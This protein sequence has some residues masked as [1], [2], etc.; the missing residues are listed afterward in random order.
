ML[1]KNLEKYYCFINDINNEIKNNILKFKNISL[2]YRPTQQQLNNLNFV[3][4]KKFCKKNSIKLYGYDNHKI[5]TK[6]NLQGLVVSS[7]YNRQIINPYFK[8][9]FKLIGI[10][11]NQIE[12]FNKYKQGC[13]VIML[14]PL[15]YNKKFSLNKILSP[16]KFKLITSNWKTDICALGGLNLNNIKKLKLIKLDAIGFCSLIS[17]QKIKKPADFLK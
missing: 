6:N 8:D 14:S 11:H 4:I 2:I 1:K 7:H 17:T 10:A 9:K 15:F 13:S 12:Y 5:V 3:E 16:I